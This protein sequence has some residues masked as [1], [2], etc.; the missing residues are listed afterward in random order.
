MSSITDGIITANFNTMRGAIPETAETVREITRP[1]VN[2]ME[3]HKHGKRGQ[4]YQIQTV[5]DFNGAS[6][7]DTEMRKYESLVG[8]IV[9]VTD[10][11]S[12][13]HAGHMVLEVIS[14]IVFAPL[15]SGGSSGSNCLVMAIWTLIDSSAGE[16]A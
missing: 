7:C 2:G 13:A 12:I 4:P 5:E 14:R 15:M 8:E 9:T 6:N 1:G 3:W 16:E 11:H 10:D